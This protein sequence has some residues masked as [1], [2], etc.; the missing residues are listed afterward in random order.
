MYTLRV[1]LLLLGLASIAL[2]AGCA[3]ELWSECCACECE[4]TCPATGSALTSSEE[5]ECWETC[6]N[7]CMFVGCGQV[8]DVE[9]CDLEYEGD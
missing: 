7:L 9:A 3:E 4:Q 6:E 1:C 2:F 8:V 5:M